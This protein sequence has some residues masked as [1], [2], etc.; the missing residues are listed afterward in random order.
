MPVLLALGL[1][2]VVGHDLQGASAVETGFRPL[3]NGRDLD[4]WVYG[5][6]IGKGYQVHGGAIGCSWE[7]CGILYTQREYGDFVLR[8]QLKLARDVNS[9]IAVRSPLSAQPWVD[10]MEVQVIDEDG[11]KYRDI[12]PWQKHGSV[13]GVLPARTGHLRPVGEWNEEEITLRGTRVIV[14][15]N[16]AL[17]VDGDL[18]EVRDSNTLAQHPGVRN[19]RGH[20][21]LIGQYPGPV[22]YRNLRIK[23]L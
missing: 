4:G 23:E 5:Q 9:G 3:L 8:F 1:L 22:E 14:K 19:R 18:A 17:I 12:K 16:G 21:G 11:P 20:V 13:Y 7:D 2:L 10:G 15:L 6:K